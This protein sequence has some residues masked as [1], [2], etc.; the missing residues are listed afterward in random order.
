MA[1]RNTTF[2]FDKTGTLTED[3]LSVQGYRPSF[4]KLNQEKVY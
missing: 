1:G 4:E 3:G 2:V